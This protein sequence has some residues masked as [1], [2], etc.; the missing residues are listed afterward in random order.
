MVDS[1]VGMVGDLHGIMGQAIDEPPMIG[2]NSDLGIMETLG[3]HDASAAWV[4]MICSDS[5]HY[6]LRTG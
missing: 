2:L 4:A 6:S 3:Y 5:G 1:T